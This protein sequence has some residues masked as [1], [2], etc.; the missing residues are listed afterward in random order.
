M[1]ATFGPRPSCLA[2]VPN[3][4]NLLRRK[5]CVRNVICP[6]NCV[7]LRDYFRQD[8]AGRGQQFQRERDSRVPLTDPIQVQR[9]GRTKDTWE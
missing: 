4:R 5:N 1:N 9:V 8:G 2:L 6:S 7:H 3:A